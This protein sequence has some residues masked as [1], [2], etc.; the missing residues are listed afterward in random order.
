MHADCRDYKGIRFGQ[1]ER[2]PEI[3]WTIPCPDREHVLNPGLARP[4]DHRV[5]V[6]FKLFVVQVAMRIGELHCYFRRA[7]T[8][9]SSLNP[10]STGKSPS[11][12]AATIIPCEVSPR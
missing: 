6:G 2:R 5:A 9:T 11:K 3:R 12:L 4:F 1:A 10:A 8:G 7:P